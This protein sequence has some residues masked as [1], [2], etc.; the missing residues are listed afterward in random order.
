M[1]DQGGAAQVQ[2]FHQSVEVGGEGA[3]VVAAGRL[4]GLAEPAPVVGDHPVARLQQ[5]GH[6]PVP[7]AA[8]ERVPVDQDHRW[9]GAV[10][11][12]MQLDAGGVLLSD[13]DVWHDAS[14]YGLRW[15]PSGRKMPTSSPSGRYVRIW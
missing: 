9:T 3:V 14:S 2:C 8:A 10:V 6:L 1:P 4:A 15:L 13:A 5:R 12:V 7:R 11:F